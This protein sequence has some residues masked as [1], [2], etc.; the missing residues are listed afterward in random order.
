MD[1]S[2]WCHNLL[3]MM[4][5]QEDSVPEMTRHSTEAAE[6]KIRKLQAPAKKYKPRLL[7]LVIRVSTSDRPGRFTTLV[8][9]CEDEGSTY[10]VVMSG[11]APWTVR[12]N[13]D[14]L[15]ALNAISVT[16]A[17]T[18]ISMMSESFIW[19]DLKLDFR[20]GTSGCS[21]GN[22]CWLSDDVRA[23]DI[24]AHIGFVVGLMPYLHN[25]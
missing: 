23:N 21:V 3:M 5:G 18:L 13:G 1:E 9:E 4:I 24:S 7:P 22:I 25:I 6:E 14:K 19:N 2:W 15:M 8:V 17:G 20:F 12:T 16:V 11:R 10:K